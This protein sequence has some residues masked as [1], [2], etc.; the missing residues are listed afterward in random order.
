LLIQ[1]TEHLPALVTLK[2][3]LKAVYSRST[4]TASKVLAESKKLCVEGIELYSEDTPGHTLG[5]LLQRQDIEAVIIVL[6]IPVQPD[7]I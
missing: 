1:T 7:I 4:K 2:A 3:K 5:D 6:P